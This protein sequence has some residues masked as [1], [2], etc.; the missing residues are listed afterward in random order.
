MGGGGTI[1]DVLYEHPPS[2]K[3]TFKREW[4]D[5]I[6]NWSD[7]QSKVRVAR[8]WG[9]T[10]MLVQ[11]KTHVVRFDELLTKYPADAVTTRLS[12]ACLW[13]GIDT[14]RGYHHQPFYGGLLDLF[15]VPKFSY[16]FFQS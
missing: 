11:A 7:Q 10:P 16:F 5:G 14:Y 4:G 3:P 2:D 13:A 12:G 8:A 9:E 15:R 1:L 6:D